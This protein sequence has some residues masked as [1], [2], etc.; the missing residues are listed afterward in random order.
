MPNDCINIV[1]IT[2]RNM[3]MLDSFIESDLQAIEEHNTKYHEVLKVYK[4][5][6]CGIVFKLW[7]RW[8]PDV[9]WFETILENY[10][11]FWIKNEWSEEGGMAGVW[12][13][14]MIND[15]QQSIESLTWR[16]LSIEEESFLFS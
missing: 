5:G 15:N 10:P 8:A 4:R 11:E 13:G 12:I 7:S 9:K 3:Q 2:C 1:T 6:K 14:F 16:D